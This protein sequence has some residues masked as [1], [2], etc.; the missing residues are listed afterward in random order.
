MLL[1]LPLGYTSPNSVMPAMY[2]ITLFTATKCS[3]LGSSVNR[4]R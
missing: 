4:C 3:Y 1:P 2:Q